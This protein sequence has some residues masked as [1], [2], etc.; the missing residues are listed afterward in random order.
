M[1]TIDKLQKLNIVFVA[2]PVPYSPF[3]YFGYVK[4]RTDESKIYVKSLPNVLN[5]DIVVSEEN[6]EIL[7]NNVVS[8][9]NNEYNISVFKQTC[10]LSR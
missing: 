1:N 3:E 2:S 4:D 5:G 7:I 9:W 6:K 10:R 8:L